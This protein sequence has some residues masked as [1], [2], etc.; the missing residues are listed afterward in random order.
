MVFSDNEFETEVTLE[1]SKTGVIYEPPFRM[2]ILGDWSGDGEKAD[3]ASRRTIE[4]DRDNFDEVM[5]RMRLRANLGDISLEF[6]DLDDFHPDQLFRRLPLFAELRDLRK[7]L[8]NPDTFYSAAREVRSCSDAPVV[9]A[10]E[11]EEEIV[12]LSGNLLDSILSKP[13]GGAPPPKTKI[14]NDLSGLISDLVRP[15]IVSVDENEQAGMLA[16]VDNAT[17]GLMRDI[18]HHPNFQALES[19]WRGL[20]FAVRRIETGTDL[21]IYVLNL[22]KDELISDLKSA[23]TL[24]DSMFYRT[25]VKEGDEPWAA[26][27]GNYAFGPNVDDIAALI[28]LGQI[29]AAANSPFISHM[30]PDVLGIHS[31]AEHADPSD[32]DMSADTAARKLWAALRDQPES[33]FLG[34]TIPRLLGRLPYG[35]DTDPAETFSFEEFTGEIEHEN[36]LWTNSAFAAALLLAQSYS[37]YGWD[38]GRSLI[39]DIDGLPAHVYKENGETVFKPCAETLL[40]LAACEKLMDFGLMPVVSYKNADHVKLARFQSIADPITALKGRWR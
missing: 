36:Y 7:R 9:E 4:V 35:A 17:S 18:L 21:K 22:S 14:S 23:G 1:R 30:R 38:M 10:V 2:L 19:A 34:M 3:P 12:P 20:H 16:A 26:I 37:E 33:E 24:S 28:R 27:F 31:L 8:V 39:Q 32:W 29:A 15:Y 13:S 6:A 11:V 25:S 40:T 5:A